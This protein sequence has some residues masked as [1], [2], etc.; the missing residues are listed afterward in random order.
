[1]TE[2]LLGIDEGTSA[3]K[4]VLYDRTSNRWR[5][6]AARSRSATRGR[7]GS[8]RIQAVLVAVIDAVAELLRE[9]DGEIV[10]CGLDHQ[11]ES[12]LA[13]DA[14]SG[15]PLTPIVTWQ[16]KRS[17]EILDELE[18]DGRAELVRDGRPAR[19]LLLRRQARLAAPQQ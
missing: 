11:G 3:V 8:S 6:R 16:D 1:M 7:A 13:W 17:Q 10:A 19:S 4:A 12:V 5:R 2:L 18:A 9:A 14:E 15:D